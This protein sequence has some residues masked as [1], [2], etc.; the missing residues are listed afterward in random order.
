MPIF[1]NNCGEANNE[2]SQVCKS[3]SSDL[4]SMVFDDEPLA[5][6]TILENRYKIISHMNPGGMSY[7]YKG[8]VLKLDST[9]VIKELIPEGSLQEQ[10]EAESWFRR[11]AD[12]L[13]KLDHPNLP[14]VFDYFVS[15]F[16]YYLVMSFV[17][18]KDLIEILEADGNPGLPENKVID[19]SGQILEVLDY[20]HTQN[21]PIIYRDIKPDN[22]MI[23]KDGRAMLIDFGIARAVHRSDDGVLK[24]AIGT[25]GYAPMEQYQGKPEPR[26]D[27]Y[28]LGATMYHVLTGKMPVPLNIP[29]VKES[30][31]DINPNLDKVIIKAVQVKVENRFASAK[32]MFSA[33]KPPVKIKKTVIKKVK[34]AT[35][36]GKGQS[37][38]T[39]SMSTNSDI[40]C[41]DILFSSGLRGIHFA[42]LSYGWA[43]GDNG[44]LICTKNTGK[45]WNKEYIHTG[46]RLN[47]IYFTDL[48]HGW[49]A[50]N[51]GVILY[52]N[53]GG[54]SWKTQQSG[55]DRNLYGIYFIDVNNG[56]AVGEGGTILHT[57]NGGNS[58]W[59]YN[60]LPLKDKKSWVAKISSTSSC[61]YRVKF[62]GLDNGWIVGDRGLILHTQDGGKTWA[63]EYM[64]KRL[65]GLYFTDLNNG[66]AVG[67]GGFILHT[68][69]SGK[70]W[71]KQYTEVSYYLTAVHFTDS[72]N[73]WISG[74]SLES[75]AI[76]LHTEDGGE[77]WKFKESGLPYY[78]TG[79]YFVNKNNGW[80][81]S[82]NGNILYTDN[83]GETWNLQHDGK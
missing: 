64:E 69:D 13:S 78:L 41:R 61:L 68:S 18:G 63:E 72:K 31:P 58:P 6:G 52:T 2:S 60:I 46:S 16:R 36:E 79:V 43:A 77:N 14:K 4:H 73:G 76:I 19:W 62:F 81:I 9:C 29:P 82:F 83:G 24:T 56:W 65:N 21:P 5:E 42:D 15:N 7:L 74:G 37:L 17:D 44:T 66:W 40:L 28:A 11:E 8:Q 45:N 3:C 70:N 50:G 53:N 59:L 48:L 27:L 57:V 67:E 51:R 20:L 54:K 55:T 32:E 75:G 23:H 49:A 34:A 1:C 12:I 30:L 39:R 80:I 38:K 33:L 71:K 22:I 10:A 25:D 35:E 26:S 47:C